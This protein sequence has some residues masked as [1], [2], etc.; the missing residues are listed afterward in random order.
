[1]I[2]LGMEEKDIKDV[3]S[4]FLDHPI[5]KGSE[6]IDADKM[7]KTLEKDSKL[8]LTVTLNLRNLVEKPE[9]LTTWLKKSDVA[10]V[11]DRIRALLDVLP[12]VDKKWNKPWWDT[13]VE[14]PMI[15]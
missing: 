4:I 5:G 1:M 2:V 14:T 8:A 12:K 10:T 6:Q 7:R 9:T 13:A 3:C 15:D 11:V